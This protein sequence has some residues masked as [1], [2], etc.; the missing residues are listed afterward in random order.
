MTLQ[1]DPAALS[2]EE[3]LAVIEQLRLRLISGES[4][5]VDEMR[6]A[7]SCLS[8]DRASAMRERRKTS[9]DA[10]KLS[11]TVVAATDDEI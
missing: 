2:T 7:I 9:A 1:K 11:K 3:R 6:Y 8:A 10:R 5:S 4:L